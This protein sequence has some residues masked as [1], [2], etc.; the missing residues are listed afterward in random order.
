VPAFGLPKIT[1]SIGANDSSAC[2]ALAAW[3]MCAKIVSSRRSRAAISRATVD[4]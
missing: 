3:S 4:R 1:T 2:R